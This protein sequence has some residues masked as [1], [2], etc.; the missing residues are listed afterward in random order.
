[1]YADEFGVL[2]YV[3]SN[4]ERHQ[5][6]HSPIVKNS[7]VSVTNYVINQTPGNVNNNYTSRIDEFESARFGHSYYVSRFFTI[8]PSNASGYSGVGTSL[9]VDNPDQYNIKII[10]S[11][12]NKYVNSL[13]ENNYE[14]FIEK[15]QDDIN[16]TS[17]TISIIF[18]ISSRNTPFRFT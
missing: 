1:M 9:R 5:T 4:A 12:G 3:K 6:K 15:Y 11:S 18:L 16:T 13:N 17:S 8:L 10:D 2:R 14:I 7:E